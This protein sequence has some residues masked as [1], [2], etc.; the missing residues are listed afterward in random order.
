MHFKVLGASVIA[1]STSAASVTGHI[2]DRKAVVRAFNP[3]RNV[4]ST[5]T[6]LQVG[7]GNFAFGVDITGLQT[8][9]PFATMS[10][11]GWHN[12]SLPTTPG[13]TAVEDFAG[14]DWWTHDRLVNYNQPNPAQGDISSWLIQ[15]PQRLNLARIGLSFK[16]EETTEEELQDKA[17]ELDLW[18]GKISSSFKY[19]GTTVYVETWADASSDSIGISV[20]SELLARGSLEIFVD[21]PLPT[22][23]KFD[24]PFVGVSNATSSHRTTL[25]PRKGS[26][27][28][29]HDLD[30]TSYDV[31]FSW[32]SKAEISGPIKGTHRYLLQPSGGKKDIALSV[33]FSPAAAKARVPRLAQIKEA[34]QNWW[35]SFWNLGAFVDLSAATSEKAM[36]LQRRIILSQYLTAVNSASAYPPQES[37]K[38]YQ[39]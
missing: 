17:Q 31:S 3:R 28:I 4:S 8:F 33:T 23:N 2:I 18:T 6:P 35:E 14:L 21:F 10:T 19:K 27:T 13:Q 38:F 20:E 30:E 34:S 37:G 16:G 12:F 36:E 39:C 22:R 7:N 15:N 26:A 11:W 9:S 5:I 25:S 32:D 24:A 29:R 1:L